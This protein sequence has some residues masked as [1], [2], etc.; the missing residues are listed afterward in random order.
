MNSATQPSK[1][2][3]FDSNATDRLKNTN[4]FTR[5]WNRLA[6]GVGTEF[7]K[8]ANYSSMSQRELEQRAAEDMAIAKAM[9]F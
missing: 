7:R 1:I 5:F 2:R 6:E 8:P 4:S 3:S 9:G